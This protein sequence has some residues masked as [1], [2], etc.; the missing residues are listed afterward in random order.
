MNGRRPT[1]LAALLIVVALAAAACSSADDGA[2]TPSDAGATE[3]S[4]QSED[5]AA[6][7]VSPQGET[8]S[9]E[10]S[11]EADGA[12]GDVQV[13]LPDVLD[14][15]A[16]LDDDGTWTISATLSSPYDTA[17]R[18]ADAWRVIGS[19]GSVYGVRELLHDH[20][21]EQPFTRSLNGVEIPED[22]IQITIEGR[23][24]LSGWGGD[25]VTI[26]LER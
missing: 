4:P 26:P 20:A 6:A 17:D 8:S 11:P 19:D 21:T 14:A 2:A 9:D 15:T 13:L 12:E 23:D 10:A 16:Q 1:G 25:T 3:A 22:E 5:P 7:D 24:Q 18:Y